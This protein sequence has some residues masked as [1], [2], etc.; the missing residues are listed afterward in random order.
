MR[1]MKHAIFAG[2]AMLMVLIAACAPAQQ[3]AAPAG[4]APAA[5]QQVGEGVQAVDSAS[6][7]LETQ[8]ADDAAA[9]LENLTW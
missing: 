5:V 1:K 4:E 7:E 8:Q 9:V 3:K 2:V 6:E